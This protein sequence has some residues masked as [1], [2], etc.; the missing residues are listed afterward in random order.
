M[1][2]ETEDTIIL[3]PNLIDT[4]INTFMCVLYLYFGMEVKQNKTYMPVSNV[5][6]SE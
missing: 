6:E 5:T 3:L 2:L 4:A 1:A